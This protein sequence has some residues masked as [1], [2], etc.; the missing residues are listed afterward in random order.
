MKRKIVVAGWGQVTQPKQIEGTAKDPMGLMAKAS[1]RAAQM[2]GSKTVLTH[3]DGIMVVR[4]VSRHYA[5][6]AQDLAQTLGATPKFVHVSGIGGNSP[7]T[8][9]N[10]AAGMIARRELDSVLIVGAE[11]Y[12]QRDA[13]SKRVDSALFRGIPKDYPGDDLI[14]STPLERRHGIEHPLQGFPLFE[15]A[16]WAA[17]GLDLKPYLMQVGQLW[18][19]FSKTAADHPYAWTRTVKT[20]KDIITPGPSNRPV[21]FPYTKNMNSFVTVDQGAAVILMSAETAKK[22][23]RKNRQTVYFLGGGYAQDRQRFMIE[24][25]DF[26]SSPP[27]KAAVEKALVRSGTVLAHLECFDLYSCFPCAVSIAKKMI[28]LADTDPRPLTLTGGLGFFGGPGN[29]YNLHAV[30]TLA[31]KIS[32]GERVNGLVTALGWFMH[33]HAAGIYGSTPPSGDF[34]VH[35]ITDQK[36]RLAGNAPV[37]I[38]DQVTGTGTI[39]TYTVIY[40]TDQTPSYA[41]VYGKTR[42]HFRFIAN[43]PPHPDIFTALTS[44]NWVGRNVRLHFDRSRNVNMAD[45]I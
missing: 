31:E 40:A 44:E 42:D 28:G 8:L 3:L 1:R 30:A 36:E 41:V 29:N 9:I 11:A 6:P 19:G 10:H 38:K 25:S 13:D 33:K 17:S 32:T 34:T 12:V 5:S 39:E 37:K 21:A 4:I 18:S 24:K 15:T 35:D 22:Y 20:P 23:S 14:G 16:L 7:Q 26:T 43:T 2:M 45:L 27:L